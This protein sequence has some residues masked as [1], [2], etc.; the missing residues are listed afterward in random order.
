MFKLIEH[1]VGSQLPGKSEHPL[2]K[3]LKIGLWAS[4]GQVVIKP[5]LGKGMVDSSQHDSAGV[6]RPK[7][8]SGYNFP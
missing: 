6:I 1:L 4:P 8:P 2:P 5:A 3:E 7:P